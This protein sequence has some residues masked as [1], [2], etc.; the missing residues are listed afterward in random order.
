MIEQTVLINKGV[1]PGAVGS[2]G[3]GG[4]DGGGGGVGCSRGV[5]ED[6]SPPV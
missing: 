6:I 1:A 4:G 2:T 3:G 5:V